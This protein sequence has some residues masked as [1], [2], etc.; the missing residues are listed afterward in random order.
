MELRESCRR[1][2]RRIEGPEET[3][4]STERPTESTYLDP[5][6][7]LEIESPSKEQA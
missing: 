5:L 6:G 3:R 1:V 2:R 7:L 4:D